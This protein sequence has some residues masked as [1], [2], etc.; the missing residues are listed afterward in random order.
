MSISFA[1]C[2]NNWRSVKLFIKA[3]HLRDCFD[4][5]QYQE[6]VR[7]LFRKYEEAS[8]AVKARLHM[9]FT[10]LLLF[11]VNPGRAKEL[12]SLRLLTDVKD[13]RVEE[14]VKRIPHGDNVI[15]FSNSGS[16]SLIEKDYKTVSKYGTNVVKFDSEFQFLTYHLREYSMTSR[17]KLLP[18]GAIH[19]YYFVNNSGMPFNSSGSFLKYLYR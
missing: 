6:L 16:V 19:D 8:G 14:L 10:M 9:N 12:R 2:D 17:P 13:N 11:S 1:H 4:P 7:S 3:C 5:S 15:L 18:R